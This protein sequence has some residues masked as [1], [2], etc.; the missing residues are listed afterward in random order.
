[1]RCTS[2]PRLAIV[3][4]TVCGCVDLNF[5]GTTEY[6]DLTYPE[7]LDQVGTSGFDPKGAELLSFRHHQTRDGF[8]MWYQIKIA[9]EDWIDILKQLDLEDPVPFASKEEG[10][11]KIG[12][13]S[14]WPEPDPSHPDWW[15]PP[16][17]FG[18]EIVKAVSQ[19]EK[20]KRAI[21]W[22]WLYD[23]PTSTAIGWK[24]NQ[25]YWHG[26]E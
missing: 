25:Q 23:K 14:S 3:A 6:R 21:G 1:M 8:Q 12:I 22:Y 16:T 17:E 19:K 2:L 13:P 7:Y 9:E 10:S 4:L 5:E 24:W 18:T 15:T 11:N 20:G 26:A